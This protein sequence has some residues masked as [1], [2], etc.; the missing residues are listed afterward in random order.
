MIT[1]IT[2]V[3]TRKKV[4]FV[5]D[6]SLIDILINAIISRNKEM[7]NLLN[8]KTRDKYRPLIKTGVSRE[9]KNIAFCYSYDLIARTK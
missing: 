7:S 4:T 2:N 9:G 5:N 8:I 3:L 6:A 1:E